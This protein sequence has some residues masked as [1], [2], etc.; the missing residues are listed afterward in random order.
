MRS[1][2]R[3]YEIR[4]GFVELYRRVRTSYRYVFGGND[5]Y[6]MQVDRPS[7]DSAPPCPHFVYH[8]IVSADGHLYDSVYGVSGIT[9]DFMESI[10]PVDRRTF[11]AG[12]A[13]Q[14][15]AP[16]RFGEGYK[17]NEHCPHDLG[18]GTPCGH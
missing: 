1:T 11:R 13:T 18:G 2:T 6:S 5:L 16:S 15:L 4:P 9:F 3:P 10:D 12:N 14:I 8:A 7:E 17:T